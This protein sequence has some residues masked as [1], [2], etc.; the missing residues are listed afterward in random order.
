[1]PDKFTSVSSFTVCSTPASTVG[2]ILTVSVL[3]LSLPP[4]A[5]NEQ[6]NV[7]LINTEVALPKELIASVI[8]QFLLKIFLVCRYD[9]KSMCIKYESI[10]NIND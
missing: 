5:A 1:V 2:A 3:A 9:K 4:Q 7:K 8:V 10:I 6:I